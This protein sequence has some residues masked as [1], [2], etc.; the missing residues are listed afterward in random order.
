MSFFSFKKT[1]VG[2]DIFDQA[3]EVVQLQ[4]SGSKISVVNKGRTILAPGLIVQGKVT[5]KK[6]LADTLSSLLVKSKISLVGHKAVVFGL[7]DSQSYVYNFSTKVIKGN[8]YDDQV[9]AEL[10]KIVPIPVEELT[11]GYTLGFVKKDNIDIISVGGDKHVVR[12]WQDFFFGL[13]AKKVLI[14]PEKTAT[15]IGRAVSVEVGLEGSKASKKSVKKVDSSEQEYIEATGLAISGIDSETFRVPF[16]DDLLLNHETIKKVI[17]QENSKQESEETAEEIVI[18]DNVD[19]DQKVRKQKITLAVISI[20]GLVVVGLLFMYQ[21]NQEQKKQAE[22]A[23]KKTNFSV[24]QAFNVDI[25]VA[26]D[27]QE[28]STGRIGGRLFVDNITTQA[29]IEEATAFSKIK[30]GQNLAIGEKL[31]DTPVLSLADKKNTK[32]PLSNKKYTVTWLIY[33]DNETNILATNKVSDTF[34]PLGIKFAISNIEKTAI[35]QSDNPQVYLL[36]V[37]LSIALEKELT[38]VIIQ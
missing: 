23:A 35:N 18:T 33:N 3:I 28:L 38:G 26:V 36:T 12:D 8:K 2:I 10:T 14:A 37:I 34:N 22:L 4:K 32:A 16:F 9:L 20:V 25:P 19:E 30:A 11:V 1:T 13:G 17:T 31:W 15:E 7:P 5:D 24:V 21:A 6:L 29:E 27:N